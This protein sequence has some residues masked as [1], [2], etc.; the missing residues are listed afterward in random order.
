MVFTPAKLPG[1]FVVDIEPATDERGLFARSWCDGE[2]GRAGIHVRFVQHNISYNRQAGTMRG[3][4][5]Q[6][7]PWSEAK[8]VRC[9][10]GAIWD[11]IVDVRD[12]SPTRYGWD[13][14]ELTAENRRQLYVP[15]GLAHG[16]ITLADDSE[17]LYHMSEFYHPESARGLRWD[18][19][20]VNIVWP[21]PPRVISGRDL[22][23]PFIRPLP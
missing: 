5:Y 6:A 3:L 14:Y 13:A 21:M 12:E 8:L 23:Y 20:V 7:P 19:P 2:A 11:V 18:D 10:R 16:F 17:V 22:T 15:E 4:H 1:A 9:T